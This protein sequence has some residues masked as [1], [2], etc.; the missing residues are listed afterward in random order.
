ME[1]GLN[2]VKLRNVMAESQRFMIRP[3]ILGG[4]DRNY[5]QLRNVMA[6]SQRFMISPE[7]LRGFCQNY[8]QDS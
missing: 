3:E 5:V 4:F 6:G 1:L 2:Y 7:I 8:H